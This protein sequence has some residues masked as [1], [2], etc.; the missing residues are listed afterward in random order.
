MR[1]RDV[2]AACRRVYAGTAARLLAGGSA[3]DVVED[4]RTRLNDAFDALAPALEA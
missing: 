3:D 2:V 1:D 4:H